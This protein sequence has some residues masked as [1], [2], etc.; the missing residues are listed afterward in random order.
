MSK[1]NYNF[2][3]LKDWTLL[4]GS[5]TRLRLIFIFIQDNKVEYTLE[6][7]TKL[8]KENVNNVRR[9]LSNLE[10]GGFL[11]SN[12]DKDN[13]RHYHLSPDFSDWQEWRSLFNKKK[14][15][16]QNKTQTGWKRIP[17]LSLL[18]LTGKFIGLNVGWPIDVLIVGDLSI[19]QIK[20]IIAKLEET[21]GEE[22]NYTH[23]TTKDF[24]YRY[25]VAD[26]FLLRILDAQH[27][28]L[29]DKMRLGSRPK[30]LK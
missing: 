15:V 9:E 23:F 27:E 11:V 17:G 21:I 1:S 8:T 19:K 28:I 6:S 13:K 7:L 24:Y 5:R 30:V 26:Q 14:V 29:V 10:A 12:H 4:F 22:V 20:N 16:H 2:D 18:I 3:H 25:S